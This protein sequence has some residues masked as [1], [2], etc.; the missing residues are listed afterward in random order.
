MI[1]DSLKNASLYDGAHPSLSYAFALA[2]S[3]SDASVPTGK[4]EGENGVYVVK[5]TY[6]TKA[7]EGKATYEAH[8]EYIDLQ[9]LLDGEE[10]ILVSDLDDCEVTKPYEPDCLLGVIRDGAAEQALALRASSFAI[11]Y[12]TDAHAPGLA[13]GEPTEVVKLVVK[14]PAEA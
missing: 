10:C 4:Y 14:I 3:V 6:T 5:S 12:P 11:L 7:C 2:A 8:R 1:F 9:I 13:L